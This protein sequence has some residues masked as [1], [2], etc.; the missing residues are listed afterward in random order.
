[1]ADPAP[2]A[3]AKPL[4]WLFAFM[5]VLTLWLTTRGWHN[6]ILDRHEFR[7]LQTATSTY[8][9]KTGGY[10][11]DYE[12]PLF[13]PPWSIPMEFPV[14]Q[15]IV[16]TLCNTLS[17]PLEETARGVS[18]FFLF[19]LLPAVY[20]LAGFFGL[21][22]SRRLLV[23]AAVL[24]SP[25]YLFYSRTFMIETTAL[26]FSTWF[27]YALGR[28]V[29]D[30]CLRCAVGA[31]VFAV[32]AALAKAT[33]FLVF[34]P[35]AAVFAFWLWRPRWQ[36]RTQPGARPWLGA[37]LAAV[38][39]LAAVGIAEWWVKRSDHIKHSNPFS[40]FL[41]ST[42]LVKWNWGTWAQRTSAE[43][44]A[45]AWENIRTCVL[46][47]VPLAVML[48]AF[49]LVEAPARRTAAWCAAFF[50][51]GMLLFSNLF[52]YHDYYYSANALFLLLAG[53]FLLA[54]VWD[55]ARLPLAAR[56]LV[57]ALF[58]G[59]QLLTY[60]RGYAGHLR[61]PPPPPPGI[62]TI[63]RESVPPEGVVL[64]YGWD[65]NSEIPYYAQ[66]RAIS[67]P[68]GRE[69]EFKVLG[70]ILQKLPPRKIAAMLIRHDPRR[71]NRLEFVH[72]RTTRFN[73]AAAPFATS[74][75]GELYLPEDAIPAAAA[76][77]Q[78]RTFEGVTLNTQ[79]P[80]DPN[81][82]KLQPN[83][84]T[85]LD[86]PMTSPRPAGA[87]SMFGIAIGEV[88]LGRKVILAHPE[89]EI[90]FTPPP[91][92]TRITAEAGINAAA[93]APDATAVTDGVSI[94]IF[95]LRADGLR[96][97]LYKRDLDPV[98]VPGDRGPQAIMIDGAGP[99][100]G[101]VV[102]KI[103]PGEKNNF[104]NDWAYWGRIEIR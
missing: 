63:I 29:R 77:L 1:M 35:P 7:Q 65:W 15:W 83:D 43:F 72:V 9:L 60:Y 78:G 47:E 33:T 90:S 41:A 40:G 25:T 10:K 32:L 38:P 56:G 45:V 4:V 39:V 80:A 59:G 74:E 91:G 16:A 34:L 48:L 103:S 82:G 50:L 76:R 28:A 54:G 71:V 98:R 46:G 23:A 93:Y 49:A 96:R 57:V 61:H 24:A 12:L 92:A 101:S 104:V 26:C 81:A 31:T 19:A 69:E 67:V 5:L 87:R 30:N 13:G 66:R 36:T 68:G 70:D 6:S 64:I 27:L 42:E 11:L 85:G 89:S 86:F 62:A 97:V 22:P 84:L 102:F 20:G 37:V 17:T 99:F 95:E 52:F 8:W 55:N 100:T 53:G 73:L 2:T 58:F 79:P 94:T 44:W 14:Y 75:E 3:P 51:G 88:G 21:A 18:V